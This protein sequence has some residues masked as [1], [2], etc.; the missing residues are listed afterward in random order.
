MSSPT[1][2]RK[3]FAAE[4][5]VLDAAKGLVEAVFSVTGNLDRQGDIIDPGAFGKA[6]SAKSSV[7][8]VYAHKWDDINQVLGKTVGWR[9][10]MPGDPGLPVSLQQKGYGG[11]KATLQFDQETPAGRV[12]FTHVKNKNIT[13]YSF[14]FDID[15]DGEKFDDNARHIKSISEVFEV[16]LALIGANPDTSTMAFK[17]LVEAEAAQTDEYDEALNDL[18][19]I[20]SSA[21][22]THAA[23]SEND[24]VIYRAAEA[25]ILRDLSAQAVPTVPVDAK[26][27]GD[28]EPDF[29]Q[30]LRNHHPFIGAIPRE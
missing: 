9:E 7:P 10:L 22:D 29:E 8:L 13:E 27:Q 12:A 17:S 2:I 24:E 11:V 20:A 21:I 18:F 28:D 5:K 23:T 1:L 3:S 19:E 25:A 14:A 30:F 4:T 15:D 26:A 16:T 6:L